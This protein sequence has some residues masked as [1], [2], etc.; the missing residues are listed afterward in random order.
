MTRQNGISFIQALLRQTE[1]KTKSVST[2]P[3]NCSMKCKTNH[4]RQ[5]TNHRP[6][7]TPTTSGFSTISGFFLKSMTALTKLTNRGCGFTTVL[8]SSGWNCVPTNQ[9]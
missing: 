8:L 2:S 7:C 9:G 4:E 1:D 6:Y 5:T 3:G